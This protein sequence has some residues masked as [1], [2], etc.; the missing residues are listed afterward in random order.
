MGIHQIEKEQK[1]NHASTDLENVNRNEKDLTGI[2]EIPE[3]R[4]HSDLY[5]EYQD[6]PEEKIWS[7][8]DDVNEWVPFYVFMARSVLTFVQ[9]RQGISNREAM[10]NS[11][12]GYA[13]QYITDVLH[14]SEYSAEIALK[15]LFTKELPRKLCTRWTAND[16]ELFIKG[17][18]KHGKNFTNIRKDLLPQK[19]TKDIVDFYYAWK[20]SESAKQLR[21]CRHSRRAKSKRFP[22]I[23]CIFGEQASSKIVTRS[24]TAKQSLKRKEVSIDPVKNELLHDITSIANSE[25]ESPDNVYT[26]AQ[27]HSIKV[28]PDVGSVKGRRKL[29]ENSNNVRRKRRRNGSFI[30]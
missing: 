24:V 2:A 25:K 8:Q 7:P 21:N 11:C 10:E 13:E 26:D 30:V 15:T 16:I 14:D 27:E 29:K 19:D 9:E 3:F 28:L 5:T 4:E 6:F 12:T 23:G 22:S 1:L 20:W 18:T 17:I